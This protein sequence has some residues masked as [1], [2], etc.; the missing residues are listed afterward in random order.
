[1]FGILHV[2]D[3]FCGG[4]VI[5]T[6]CANMD[7]HLLLPKELHERVNLVGMVS[8]SNGQCDVMSHRASK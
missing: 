7:L 8:G 4:V 2:L 1:M 6:T 3:N 5:N